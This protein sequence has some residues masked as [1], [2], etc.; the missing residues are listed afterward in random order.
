MTAYNNDLAVNISYK[1]N[2]DDVFQLFYLQKDAEDEFSENNSSKAEVKSSDIFEKASFNIPLNTERIRIDFGS[3]AS[4]ICIE[5]VEI[6][7]LFG[8][9]TIEAK[10]ILD[11]AAFNDFIKNKQLDNN[12]LYFETIDGDPFIVLDNAISEYVEELDNQVPYFVVVFSALLALLLYLAVKVLKF[13]FKIQLHKHI[14][15]FIKD[16][17]A[18]RKLILKLAINDFKTK[19][20][21]SYFGIVWAFV[22]PV[23][24]ILTF[25]FVFQVGFRSA[26]VQDY[27]FI[28]WFICGIIPWFFFSDSTMNAMNSLIEYNYLVKKIVFKISILPLIKVIS[29][30]F[31]H[32]FFCAFIFAAFAIRGY[33]P[34]IY[35]IQFV[36]YLIC[37]FVLAVSIS[38]ITSS[39]IIFF[40]DFGQIVSI[41]LQ[42]GMWFT[43]IMWSYKMIPPKYDIIFKL[44]PM[45]YIVEGYR[46]SFIN[47]VW[48]F[49]KPNMTLFFWTITTVLFVMGAYLFK[50]LKPHFSDVL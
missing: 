50:K 18:G 34:N 29:S 15:V 17:Y 41:V 23:I 1:S 35:N 21:G 43:P 28:L 10:D 20:A 16:I 42:I 22:Q 39:I 2:M 25:W 40:K 45:F 26:P 3:K 7:R 30:L 27:P 8:K 4:V 33:M 47:K 24:T 31:V 9:Y 37:L 14:G 12:V 49:E 6:K 46:D 11:H 13:A 19:Y 32:V 44:N 48:F 5:K 38:F 36:Y